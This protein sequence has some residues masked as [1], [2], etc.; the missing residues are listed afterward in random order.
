MI[1]FSSLLACN[2]IIS[3]TKNDKKKKKENMSIQKW[4]VVC[5]ISHVSCEGKTKGHLVLKSFF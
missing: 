5:V 3:G 2:G 1:G 4:V